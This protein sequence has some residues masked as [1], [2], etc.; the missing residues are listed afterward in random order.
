M[1]LDSVTLGPRR[2]LMAAGCP[3]I[4]VVYRLAGILNQEQA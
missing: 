3:C 2:G 1:A 4:R